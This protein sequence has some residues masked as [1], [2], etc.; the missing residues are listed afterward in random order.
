MLGERVQSR[1]RVKRL[2][3]LLSLGLLGCA[4]TSEP[5][6]PHSISDAEMN[7]VVLGIHAELKDLDSPRF[8]KFK[9]ANAVGEKVYICGWVSDA[10]EYRDELPFVGTLFAG[11]FVLDHIGKHQTQKDFILSECNRMGIPL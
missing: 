3:L 4:T 8:R 5:L 2:T 6:S 1:T 11:Q 9:A 10:G 7:A